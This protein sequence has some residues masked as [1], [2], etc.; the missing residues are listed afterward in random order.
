[1]SFISK[2]LGPG[3]DTGFF[4]VFWFYASEQVSHCWVVSVSAVTFFPFCRGGMKQL[5]LYPSIY[6][7]CS[8]I[9]ILLSPSGPHSE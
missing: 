3:S 4:L 7:I 1:M 5:V 9:L 8:T 2:V 6:L